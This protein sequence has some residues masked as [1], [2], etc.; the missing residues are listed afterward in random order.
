MRR[1][2]LTGVAVAVVFVL[3]ALGLTG[4]WAV[5]LT[6]GAGVIV[7]VIAA[8][9]PIDAY[10]RD[11]IA[12]ARQGALRDWMGP[13]PYEF[14]RDVADAFRAE[15]AE[16]KGDRLADTATGARLLSASLDELARQ[17]GIM[18]YE[19]LLRSRTWLP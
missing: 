6:A 7:G 2:I 5:A 15:L 13:D 12:K 8:S 14:A 3:G 17:A 16:A 1:A 4:S 18:R 10:I 11:E 9:T 19:E